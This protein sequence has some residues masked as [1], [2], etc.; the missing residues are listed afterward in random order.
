MSEIREM[1]AQLFKDDFGQPMTLT[2]GQLEIFEM[3]ATRSVPNQDK[4]RRVHVS[5]HTRYGKSLAAGLGV[6]TR[7]SSF[8]EKWVI[9][10]GSKEKAQIIMNYVNAHIFDN[11]YISK[12]FRLDKG[13]T[14]ESIKRYRNKNH[15]TFDLSDVGK[16]LIGEIFIT[17]GKEAIGLGS[18]NLIEDEAALIPDNEHSLIMRML[19]DHPEDNFL[20]KIGNPFARNHFLQSFNDPAYHKLVID[21][22]QGLREGRI[23]EQVIEENRPYAYFKVLYECLFPTAEEMDES[24]FMYLLTDNDLQVATSR[25]Q[26][27]HGQK[28]LGVDVARGGRNYNV[29]VLRGANYAK[30]IKKNHDND[31]MSVAQT[32]A[33]IMR[34]E[35]IP[36]DCV[37]IDD[38]GVGGGVTDRLR[39]MGYTVNAVRLGEAAEDPNYLNVRSEAYAGKEGMANWIKRTGQLVPDAG[40]TEL[41]VIRYKKNSSGKLYIESKDDMRKRGIQSPDVA[42][43]LMLTFAKSQLKPKFKQIDPRSILQNTPKPFLP[44]IG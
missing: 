25:V 4:I 6:L 14:A 8:P 31:L 39:E 44:G 18:A 1:V 33:D 35:Q 5:C 43:G 9:A 11:E 17:S 13:E 19:G 3:I 34:E 20:M 37:F 16:N 10:A 2:P 12:R 30:V 29:W 32:T 38:T 27:W 21:C 15:I 42:D 26:E 28:R 24:G 40:W 22:Y 23:T 36:G 7:A 41:L